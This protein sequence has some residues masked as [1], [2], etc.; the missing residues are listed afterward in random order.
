MQRKTITSCL[1]HT[2][3]EYPLHGIHYVNETGNEEV[4]TYAELL[5]EAYCMAS[6]FL[7][8]GFKPGEKV[9]ITTIHNRQTITTLWGCFFAGLVPT[10]L[11][12]PVTL[13]DKSQAAEKLVNVFKQLDQPVII[14]SKDLEGHSD[15]PVSKFRLFE[16][17]Q[18]IDRIPDFSPE[19]EMLTFI[20][21]SS[22]STGEPKG[23]MLTHANLISNIASIVAGL[24]LTADDRG[25]NWMPLYHDM[26][27]I[28]FHLTPLFTGTNQYHIE[29]IDFIKN[30]SLWL[31]LLSNAGISIS[32]SPNF[33][34]S[35]I[36][37]HLQRKKHG[38]DWDFSSM[39]AL[40]NGA[41]PISVKIMEEF[42]RA[43]ERHG[44]PQNAMMPVYGMAEATLA[45]SF[46]PLMKPSVTSIFDSDKL[47]LEGLAFPA[48]AGSHR[49]N[50][51]LTSVGMALKDIEIRIVNE[52]DELLPEKTVGHIQIKGSAVTAGYY[53]NPE[54]TAS[55]FSGD[56]LRTGDLG[57][58]LDG[59]LYISGRFKD[60]IFMNGKN[61]FANDLE[62]LACSMEE[63]S[64]GKVAFGG[65]TDPKS[66]KDKI[67]IFA[68][69]IPESK[70][71]ET[72]QTLRALFRKTFGIPVDE[73]VIMRSN[74]FPK[75]SSGKIQRYKILQRY[76]QGD[77]ANMK[78]R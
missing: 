60:I 13:S 28:G 39:K 15:I 16:D 17:L 52:N 30:P 12:T 71:E 34:L 70:A 59:N 5:G 31:D 21:Y 32:G 54:A 14:I 73:M 69:G 10:I 47:D 75:T 41:E 56:W 19:S 55:L 27:L 51:Q 3:R 9:I 67:I 44:F 61:Y 43:L 37:R 20:Q 77:F 58:F 57:F 76:Q 78:F 48:T 42:T 8:S 1:Q 11:Q 33:G 74:E 72:L 6:G 66:G 45:V 26:G 7:Q 29:T 23:I 64:Y 4:Q 50:R 46:T 49:H 24:E 62:S 53:K 65:I 63:I 25:G 40:L 18:R 2:A 35:L 36:L 68:A 38:P 22:G